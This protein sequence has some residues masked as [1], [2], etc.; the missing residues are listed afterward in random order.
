MGQSD[1]R[2]WDV[3]AR[4]TN[5]YDCALRQGHHAYNWLRMVYT[6]ENRYEGAKDAHGNPYARRIMRIMPAQL[7]LLL[8]LN[9]W[10]RTLSS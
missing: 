9:M 7:G 2:E 8:A 5:R 3:D 4:L 1:G 10:L 6:T